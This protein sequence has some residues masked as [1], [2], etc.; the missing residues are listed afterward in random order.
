[1]NTGWVGGK[2]GEGNRISLKDTRAILDAIYDGSLNDAKYETMP[3]FNIEFPTEVNNV[4]TKILNPRDSWSNKD[5][6][7]KDVK[8]LAVA[9]QKNFKRYEAKTDKVIINAGPKI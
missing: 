6:Y 3:V 2:Y 5:D 7:D 9:F 1:M 4:P 8:T